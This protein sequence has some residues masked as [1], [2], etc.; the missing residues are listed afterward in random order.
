MSDEDERVMRVILVTHVNYGFVY[1]F[2]RV[3]TIEQD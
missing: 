3:K 2:N 1:V